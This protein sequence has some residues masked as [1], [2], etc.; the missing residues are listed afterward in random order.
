MEEGS[1]CTVLSTVSV[2]SA[3]SG[4]DTITSVSSIS[5]GEVAISST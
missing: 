5:I 3:S 2:S 1:V 4:E